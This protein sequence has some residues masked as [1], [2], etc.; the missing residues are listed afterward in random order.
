MFSY[1]ITDLIFKSSYL[2]LSNT[3]H[4]TTQNN[5][6]SSMVILVGNSFSPHEILYISEYATSLGNV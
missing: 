6:S 4:V 3:K 2:N 1:E 5:R